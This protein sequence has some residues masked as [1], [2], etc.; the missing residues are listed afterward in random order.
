MESHDNGIGVWNLDSRIFWNTLLL[1]LKTAA[2]VGQGLGNVGDDFVLGLAPLDAPIGKG[3]LG[4][5]DP[6]PNFLHDTLV[7]LG[8]GTDFFLKG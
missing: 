6:P 8:A 2:I 7:E 1:A 5:T 3:S 4:E